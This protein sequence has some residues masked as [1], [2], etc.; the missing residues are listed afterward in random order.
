LE[1]LFLQYSI[2]ISNWRR[3]GEGCRVVVL[4]V[5]EHKVK[6]VSMGSTLRPK[7]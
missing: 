7:G 4:G 5:Q 1:M 3:G 2:S 6:G